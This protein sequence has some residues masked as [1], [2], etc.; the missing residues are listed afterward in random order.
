VPTAS[1]HALQVNY[2]AQMSVPRIELIGTLIP[3]AGPTSRHDPIGWAGATL[4][5]TDGFCSPEEF[6]PS[7][8]R[9]ELKNGTACTSSSAEKEIL[10]CANMPVP[11]W[12]GTDPWPRTPAHYVQAACQLNPCTPSPSPAP[13]PHSPHL[14]STPP[15]PSPSLPPSPSP[16]PSPSPLPSPSLSLPSPSPTPSLPLLSA[17][18]SSLPPPPDSVGSRVAAAPESSEDVGWL[19]EHMRGSVVEK[20]AGGL[21]R[22]VPVLIIML[23]PILLYVGYFTRRS[24]SKGFQSCA[25][26]CPSSCASASGQ[27]REC[28]TVAQ[29]SAAGDDDHMGSIDTPTAT[30]EAAD[31][32]SREV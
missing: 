8:I 30:P 14:P 18:Q 26:I 17:L 5:C 27:E 29:E 25:S 3:S 6:W 11:L 19:Q 10:S 4:G 20:S 15:L 12:A 13:P 1:F 31:P 21:P 2:P 7:S 23:L 9:F 32:D 24:R 28:L 16:M 22:T